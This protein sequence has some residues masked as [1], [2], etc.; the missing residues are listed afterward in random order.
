MSLSGLNINMGILES[1]VPDIFGDALMVAST[2]DPAYYTVDG[3]DNV[4][5]IANPGQLDDWSSVGWGSV[6]VVTDG[7]G[8]KWFEDPLSSIVNSE[9]CNPTA[10][11]ASTIVTNPNGII[12][13]VSLR[14]KADQAYSDAGRAIYN[15]GWSY[16]LG[17]PL[18]VLWRLIRSTD[19]LNFRSDMECYRQITTGLLPS[20]YDASQQQIGALWDDPAYPEIGVYDPDGNTFTT[21]AYSA[22]DDLVLC[23]F[24]QPAGWRMWI[25]NTEVTPYNDTYMNA[26]GTPSDASAMATMFALDWSLKQLDINGGTAVT[27]TTAINIGANTKMDYAGL[28]DGSTTD[29][30]VRQVVSQLLNQKPQ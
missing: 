15:S 7:D 21:P 20:P 19:S 10:G 14:A 26:D 23:F 5:D 8:T 3:S 4:T 29:S 6:D 16:Q 1:D 13:I 28:W 27:P 2:W 9:I 22:D 12:E 18:K 25:N 17:N 24:F 30:E 11:N